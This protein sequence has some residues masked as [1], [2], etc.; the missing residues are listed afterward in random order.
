[1]DLHLHAGM[2]RQTTLEKWLDLAVAD[3]RKVVVLL[4]H[5]ELY[6]RTEA[7]QQSWLARRP[8]IT[9]RYP[10]GD[11]GH[12]ALE[13]DFARMRA[14]RRDLVIF[15]GWEV[16]EKELDEGTEPDVLRRADLIGWHISPNNPGNAPDGAH[17]LRRA[18]QVRALQKSLDKPMVLFHPF[19]MRVEKVRKH[20]P[21]PTAADYRFFHGDEQRQLAEVLRGAPI[22]I[23]IGRETGTCMKEP[24]CRQA[25]LED[26]RPLVALGVRFT[27]STDAH[28]VRDQAR[29]FRPEE[30]CAPLGVTPAN[31]NTL[32][33]ELQ[34]RKSGP[35]R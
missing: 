5:L 9:A 3:G 27:V 14:T 8:D 22:W 35:A 34:K 24:A 2:E 10:R 12:R 31:V 20:H 18:R 29:T 4:D 32:V 15:T 6:R 1:M 16:S 17:L 28:S 25:M 21:A 30:F 26:I 7:E 11:A 19:T 13:A 33:Q 23:E